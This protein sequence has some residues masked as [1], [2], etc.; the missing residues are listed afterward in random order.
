[1]SDDFS[2]SV[3]LPADRDGF[4]RRE[5]PSCEREFKWFVHEEDDP[6]A[7]A[8]DQY[9]CPL[10]SVS[11][12]VDSWWTAAQLEYATAAAGPDI[13]RLVQDSISDAFKSV[14]GMTFKPS[15]NFSLDVPTAEAVTETEDMVIVQPPCHGNE[16]VKVP[17]SA[18][19]RVHCLVCGAP[20]AG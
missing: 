9:F 15:R 5:C 7:E 1:M 19:A 8:V 6:N 18:L 3:S 10:C 16:P 11:A 13:G 17:E 4:L 2:V 12:G 14:Q 20:F